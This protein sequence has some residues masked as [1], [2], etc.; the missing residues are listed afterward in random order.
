MLK[1]VKNSEYV[2]ACRYTGY[3]AKS[4]KLTLECGHEQHRK[5][6]QGIPMRARCTE[7]ERAECDAMFKAIART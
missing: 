6:S 7:C 5:A 3:V 2:G 1:A 4:V